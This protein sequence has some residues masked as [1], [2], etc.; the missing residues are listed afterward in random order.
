MFAAHIFSSVVQSYRDAHSNHSIGPKRGIHLAF[1]QR[2][3]ISHSYKTMTPTEQFKIA[4]NNRWANMIKQYADLINIVLWTKHSKYSDTGLEQHEAGQIMTEFSFWGK[5]SLWVWIGGCILVWTNGTVQNT[6]ARSEHQSERD[7]AGEREHH[8]EKHCVS[9]TVTQSFTLVTVW[10][11]H[12]SHS[13][14]L[15]QSVSFISLS[16]CCPHFLQACVCLASSCPLYHSVLQLYQLH[17]L[18]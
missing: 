10:I 14:T 12:R 8:I 6:E 16:L 11:N 3:S 2:T 5:L 18:Y 15:L 7:Q 17:T 13:L 9:G 4:M 1:Q